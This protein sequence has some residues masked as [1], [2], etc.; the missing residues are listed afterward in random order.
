MITAREGVGRTGAAI[1]LASIVVL[2]SIPFDLIP[3]LRG[4][5]PY[6]PEWQWA[7]RPEG[8]ARP[9]LGGRGLRPGPPR[10]P[11]GFRYG[12][13]AEP[14]H[15]CAAG[16]GGRSGDPGLRSAAGAAGPRAR[17]G[18]ADPAL[19]GPLGLVH[20]VPH[21]GHLAR[22]PGPGRVSPAPR[23]AA[24]PTLSRTRQ[25]RRHPPT[26]ARCSTTGPPSPCARPRRRSP[27]GS[28]AWPGSPTASFGLRPPGPPGPR[29]CSAP[30]FSASWAPSP[31]GR[32]LA[33]RRPSAPRVSPPRAWRCSG[34]SL[35]GPAL[36]VPQFDQALA[37]P[38][39]AVAALLLAAHREVG[40]GL[41]ASG[42]PAR[43]AGR[44]S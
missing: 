23:R 16:P 8:P 11:V 2:V 30:W 36:M 25:A 42:P 19:T 22:S 10:P 43:S 29:R 15:R 24:C 34:P 13:G 44:R 38:V 27:M 31:P 14:P 17:P 20:L 41:V 35:P 28:S 18:P 40:A 26:R 6:P 9:L 12:L 7:F 5:A 39:V 21:G 1:L 37:L 33:W 32:S 4:P 3:M